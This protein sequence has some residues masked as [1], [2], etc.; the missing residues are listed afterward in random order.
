MKENLHS[1]I[2]KILI[3]DT[4]GVSHLLDYLIILQISREVNYYSKINAKIKLKNKRKNNPIK[5]CLSHPEFPQQ[6]FLLMLL[7]FL[8][9]LVKNLEMLNFFKNFFN[10]NYF[11]LLLKWVCFL[12]LQCHLEP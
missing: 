4:Q 2:L 11:P 9:S 5:N 3:C 1:V 8:Q 12:K 6:S 7:H 10:I